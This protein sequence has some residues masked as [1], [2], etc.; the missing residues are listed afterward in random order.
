MATDTLWESLLLLRRS[1]RAAL[2]ALAALASGKTAFKAAV[3]NGAVP[4]ADALPYRPEVQALLDEARTRGDAVVLATAADRRIA[5]AVAAHAG[6]FDAV[7]TTDAATN[8]HGAA[9]LAAI[10]RLAAGRPFAYLGDALVDVPI[11]A[12]ADR[13][14]LVGASPATARRVQAAVP[15][16]EVLAPRPRAAF[17]TWARALRVHQWAKNL[18][19]A[20][21]LLTA[22]QAFSTNGWAR[23]AVAFVAFSLV[24]SSVYLTND[25]VDL[26]ADRVHPRKRRRPLAAGDVSIPH[27]LAAAVLLLALGAA[28]AL[29]LGPAF[30]GA[31]V[32]YYALTSAYSL[33]LKRRA[34]VD[35][36]VLAGLYT[37]RIVAGALAV[38]VPLSLWLLSFSAFLF[39]S[40]ALVKRYAELFDAAR[41]GRALAG[42]GYTAQDLPA[43]GTMGVGAALMAVL[44]LA[45]YVASDH[46]RGLYPQP[47]WLWG[48]LPL[49]LAWTMR[50]WLR[51]YRGQMHD[52]PLVFA[53]R[54]PASLAVAALGLLLV[55]LARFG[56][57]WGLAPL[58]LTW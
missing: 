51:T 6:P 29:R 53:L 36:L 33:A 47:A 42:R 32:A 22:L 54:D 5:E 18:L 46:V 44:V 28:L 7:L 8:L 20:V 19:V 31:L 15:H 49:A 25:L 40:L 16:V 17:R 9:K 3:G 1:P 37:L 58:P 57:A 26:P 41:A 50:V 56:A 14:V 39:F 48:V 52:D 21:P 34:L 27:G 38:G 4:L 12:A 45:L 11:F 30:F 43:V 10:E 24:A 35:V 13:A 23:V 55:L 2:A